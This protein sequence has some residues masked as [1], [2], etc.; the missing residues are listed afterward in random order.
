MRSSASRS[1]RPRRRRNPS[2]E[3]V[4]TWAKVVIPKSRR[5]A[6]SSATATES[7]CSL[8][9]STSGGREP[10]FSS[11]S[12]RSGNALGI[13]VPAARSCK[14]IERG[15][16]CTNEASRPAGIYSTP[17]RPSLRLISAASSAI[18]FP[19]A[20]PMS[21]VNP[22]SAISAQSRSA[23]ATGESKGISQPRRSIKVSAI[24]IDSIMRE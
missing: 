7:T 5:C 13:P 19:L 10:G 23:S 16:V 4:A 6:T 22:I 11:C 18:A 3:S 24:G 2:S 9:P 8:F 17:R 12:P 1:L 21:A 15:S 20:I 14:S